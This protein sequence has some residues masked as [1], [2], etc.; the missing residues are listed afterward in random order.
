M[1]FSSQLNFRPSP[2]RWNL[3]R[4]QFRSSRKPRGGGRIQGSRIA[5]SKKRVTC[6]RRNR[7]LNGV[8]RGDSAARGVW[9]GGYCD[10]VFPFAPF[11]GH[12]LPE[13]HQ[14]SRWKEMKWDRSIIAE[15]D[16]A[17]RPEGCKMRVASNSD[18]LLPAVA[19]SWL[20]ILE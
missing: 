14:K 5:Q 12:G 2:H 16:E 18:M 10:C 9:V 3:P 8:S 7:G 6:W 19:F 17:E 1:R 11:R 20:V 4:R 15:N 13:D